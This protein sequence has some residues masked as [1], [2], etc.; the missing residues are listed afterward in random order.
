MP[1]VAPAVKTKITL[2]TA[3]SFAV[4]QQLWPTSIHLR[5]VTSLRV[6][7]LCPVCVDLALLV[8]SSMSVGPYQWKEYYLRYLQRFAR[9]ERWSIGS[10]WNSTQV[11]PH[12]HGYNL[13]LASS[14]A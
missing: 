3:T 1:Y 6:T 2:N 10:D 11:I 5:A 9:S 4:G 14:L 13:Q 12:A 8:D 7:D